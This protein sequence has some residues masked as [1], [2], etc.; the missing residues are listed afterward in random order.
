MNETS[1]P[2]AA[3]LILDKGVEQQLLN[4]IPPDA[5][6][7]VELGCA[8]GHLGARYKCRN[9]AARYIGVEAATDAADAAT[10][11]LDQLVVAE[12]SPESVEEAGLNN[13][14][15][16]I[17]RGHL[18]S[19]KEPWK[20]IQR[21]SAAISDD[22]VLLASF[23]NAEH[24]LHA[25]K[26]FLEPSQKLDNDSH[27]THDDQLYSLN[28]IQNIYQRA[29]LNVLEIIGIAV[30]G[31]EYQKFLQAAQGLLKF[32]DIDE[33]AFTRRSTVKHYIVRAV[34]KAPEK[35]LFI[36]SMILPPIAACNDKRIHEPMSCLRTIAG[37]RAVSK[38][39]KIRIA[40]VTEDEPRIFL[41][42]RPIMTRPDSPKR[43]REI[44]RAGYLVIVE[45]DDDPR[46]WQAIVDDDYLTFRGVHAVQTSTESLAN[47]LRQFNPN[48]A[49]FPN[50]I[51]ELGQ[52]KTKKDG[53]KV[54]LFFGALNREDDW[55]PLMSSLNKI[56]IE[57]E[58]DLQIMVVHDRKFFDELVTP[59]KVFYPLCDYTQYLQLLNGCDIGLLPLEPTE[60]NQYK[61]DLKFI[62]YAAH[63]IVALASSCVYETSIQEGKTGMLF[64][65]E[66]DFEDKLR[67]LIMN[68][69]TR[70]KIANAAYQWVAENRLLGMHYR[71]RYDWYQQLL[72]RLPELNQELQQRMPE[73]FTN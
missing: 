65:N 48:V 26:F 20:D 59:N 17:T 60:F 37:V 31:M 51:M 13:V 14:D 25:R 57:F 36:Q 72:G 63:G 38:E 49:V 52:R 7:I 69:D 19:A 35:R 40:R 21:L 58:Q 11:V 44:L 43:L 9:P 28:T 46:R 64:H 33:V 41:W 50:Q 73:L 42:Q 4:L 10:N 32:Y 55:R 53:G 70:T 29:G 66:N 56:L 54:Q 6:I 61:S 2:Q 15:C 16:L 30:V 39:K 67:L 68:A 1:M 62:E 8:E 12:P 71:D 27:S 23:E 34:K 3:P 18:L 22:G 47:F 24:W 5:T 45:F